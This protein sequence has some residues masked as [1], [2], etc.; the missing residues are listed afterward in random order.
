MA[1]RNKF[2]VSFDGVADVRAYRL[3]REWKQDDKSDFDFFD[4]HEIYGK[5]ESIPEETLRQQ[6]VERMEPAQAVVCL[7]GE[8]TRFLAKYLHWELEQAIT[9]G[10]PIIG[11]NLD[12]KHSQVA[13]RCPPILL[14]K[15]V[16][17]INFNPEILQHALE[18]WPEEHGRFR[19]K[20]KAGPH[21]YGQDIYLGLGL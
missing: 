14:D 13:D 9:R 18:H 5:V 7:I 4:A 16:T 8:D 1:Y 10:L 15:L 2:L 3:M 12:G 19:S 6:L 21:Y 20:G 11:V 17:Y